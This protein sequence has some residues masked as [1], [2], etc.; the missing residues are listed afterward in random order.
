M[1]RIKKPEREAVITGITL[2]HESV[3]DA[4]KTAIIALGAVHEHDMTKMAKR[5]A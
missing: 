4:A 2:V 5:S 3:D 1:P